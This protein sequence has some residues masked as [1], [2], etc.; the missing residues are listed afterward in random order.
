MGLK[1]ER[2]GEAVEN[3]FPAVMQTIRGSR[4]GVQGFAQ[5]QQKTLP[6]TGHIFGQWKNDLKEVLNSSLFSVT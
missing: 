3:D 1:K 4:K 2:L 5:A 6:L